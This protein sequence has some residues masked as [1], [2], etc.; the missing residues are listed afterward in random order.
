MEQSLFDTWKQK[1]F[2]DFEEVHALITTQPEEFY[3]LYYR[4]YNM[5]FEEGNDEE[6]S[7][8]MAMVLMSFPFTGNQ[9]MSEDEIAETCDS[10]QF[11]LIHGFPMLN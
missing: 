7:Q 6:N 4:L 5:F 11:H 9:E 3:K 2:E 10:I 8:V 1:A